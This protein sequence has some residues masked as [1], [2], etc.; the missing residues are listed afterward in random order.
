MTSWPWEGLRSMA[1]LI[2]S[3]LTSL[4]GYIADATG[5]F[6]WAM[7]DAEVHAFAND[8]QRS[9]GT[10][11]Y[12]RRLYETMVFWDAADTSESADPVFADFAKTW[13]A[14]DKIVFSTT[15]AEPSSARTRVERAFDA[16]AVR[17]LKAEQ[18]RDLA[19]G[20]AGLAGAARWARRRDPPLPHARQR[21]QR[22]HCVAD[23]R[24]AR[25]RPRRGAPVREWGGLRAV[26][27]AG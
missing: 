8:L 26:R 21:R 14:A 9:A 24:A 25:P 5:A 1:K 11:L 20:G 12:G 4:D 22:H 16:K 23:R 3:M 17:R 2:Y 18:D 7:P 19:I 13:Q 6:D 15:L 10:Y 27:G